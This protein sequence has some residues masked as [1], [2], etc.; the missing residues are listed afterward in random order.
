MV[1]NL[2]LQI[3]AG[4]AGIWLA[5]EFVSG[6]DFAGGIKTLALAGLALGVINTFIKPVLKIITG[7]V[8]ILTLGLFSFVINM[9]IVWA[10]DILFP[11]VII[12]GIIPL[13]WT[14]LIIWILSL[15]L[16]LLGKGR[17]RRR[18]LPKTP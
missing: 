1:Q 10:V 7:P 14:A 15:F 4:I 2:V 18:P 17:L 12:V 8:I 16:T 11:E 6:V 9:L 5:S 13:F 3:I